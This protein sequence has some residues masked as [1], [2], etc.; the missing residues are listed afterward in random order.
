MLS[1]PTFTLTCACEAGVAVLICLVAYLG[2]T[3]AINVFKSIDGR[4]SSP[5]YPD[6]YSQADYDRATEKYNPNYKW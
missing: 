3:I 1:V 2:I 6:P 4:S 5:V